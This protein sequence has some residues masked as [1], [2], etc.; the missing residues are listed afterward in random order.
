MEAISYTDLYA[1][2][3]NKAVQTFI[4]NRE[5]PEDFLRF[6]EGFI[7]ATLLSIPLWTAIIGLIFYLL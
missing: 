4:L 2:L 6:F 7:Y 5:D 3:E 1:P